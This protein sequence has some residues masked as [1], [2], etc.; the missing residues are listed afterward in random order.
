MILENKSIPDIRDILTMKNDSPVIRIVMSEG[1]CGIFYEHVAFKGTP[2]F[3]KNRA[4]TFSKNHFKSMHFIKSDACSEDADLLTYMHPNVKRHLTISFPIGF[5]SSSFQQLSA[6]SNVHSELRKYEDIRWFELAKGSC[7]I[8]NNDDHGLFNQK[9]E[10]F[11]QTNNRRV[12]YF[13]VE[14]YGVNY[15]ESLDIERCKYI[16]NKWENF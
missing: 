6:N 14:H 12:Y 16:Q 2:T 13:L 7:L 5:N 8:W 15:F 10:I 3:I 11:T 9:S 4:S 1:Y